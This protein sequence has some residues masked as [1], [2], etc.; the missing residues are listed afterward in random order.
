MVKWGWGWGVRHSTQA[1][2]NTN[3]P[4]TVALSTPPPVQTL[5]VLADKDKGFMRLLGLELGPTGAPCQRFAGVV[6]NGILLRLKVEGTPG[7]LQLTTV[8]SMLD[9]FKQFFGT[10]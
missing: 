8:K 3:Y 6:D 7:D 5:C 2:D 10:N 4:A 9:T 1:S